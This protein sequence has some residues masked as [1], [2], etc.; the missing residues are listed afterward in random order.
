MSRVETIAEAPGS[1]G[2]VDTRFTRRR[3]RQTQGKAVSVPVVKFTKFTMSHEFR[4]AGDGHLASVDEQTLPLGSLVV[5]APGGGGH[6]LEVDRI[7]RG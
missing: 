7:V 3:R 2:K 6:G 1:M 5:V 4:Q